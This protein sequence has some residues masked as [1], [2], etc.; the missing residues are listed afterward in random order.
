MIVLDMPVPP[1]HN[2]DGSLRLRAN[3]PLW[4][5]APAAKQ[6]KVPSKLIPRPGRKQ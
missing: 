4:Y 2:R 3:P 5:A 1:M 6:R